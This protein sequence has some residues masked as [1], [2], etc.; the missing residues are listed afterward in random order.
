MVTT[1]PGTDFVNRRV[2]V[3]EG[4]LA[5][6]MR[7]VQAARDRD[8]GLEVVTIPQ[9]AARLAGGFSSPADEEVSIRLFHGHW[10]RR[11]S[12]TSRLSPDCRAWFAP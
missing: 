9:L 8:F 7:R 2:V 12:P 5:F 6:R 10:P 4:A 3:V 1:T 11:V